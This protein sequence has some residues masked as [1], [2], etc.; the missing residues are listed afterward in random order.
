MNGMYFRRM[1][2][3][4]KKNDSRQTC[5]TGIYIYLYDR[6]QHIMSRCFIQNRTTHRFRLMWTGKIGHPHPEKNQEQGYEKD[7]EANVS[8]MFNQH[9]HFAN[10]SDS[11]IQYKLH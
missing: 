7:Y 6:L 4:G 8:T 5:Y 3:R 11:N 1:F 2:F 10:V 9:I